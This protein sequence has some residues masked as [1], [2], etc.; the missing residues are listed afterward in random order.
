MDAISYPAENHAIINQCEESSFWFRHRLSCIS[1]M[2]QDYGITSLLDVGGGNGKLVA[3]LQA[4]GITCALLEPGVQAIQNARAAGVKILIN[5]ALTSANFKDNSIPAV[6]LFDVL[7]HIEDDNACL[8]ELHRIMSP[9]GQ[10]VLTV[11]AYMFLFSDFDRAAGHYRRYTLHQLTRKLEE[12][13]FDVT[14]KTYV[15]MMLTLPMLLLRRLRKNSTGTKMKSDHIKTSWLWR[16][17]F[18]I[19]FDPERF[20]LSRK[21]TIPFGTSCLIVAKKTNG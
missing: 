6:G 13:G 20:L 7:E 15:F 10:L 2:I 5:S 9:G 16:W 18:R 1:L 4:R 19:A 14:Y 21:L 11:P 17:A 8:Q 3:S 12:N